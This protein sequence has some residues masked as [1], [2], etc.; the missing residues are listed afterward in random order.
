MLQACLFRL[1]STVCIFENYLK[2]Q[3][4]QFS[5]HQKNKK[6]GRTVCISENQTYNRT[7]TYNRNLRVCASRLKTP[8]PVLS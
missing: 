5:M 3:N 6:W 4:F 1:Y 7:S 8:Q 2:N